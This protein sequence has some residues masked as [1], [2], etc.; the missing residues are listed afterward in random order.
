MRKYLAKR[1]FVVEKT[2][3]FTSKD[4]PA[5]TVCSTINGVSGWKNETT[6]NDA[7]KEVCSSSCSANEA[8]TCI[9]ENTFN[10]SEVIGSAYNPNSELIENS[11]WNLDISNI[12]SGQCFTLNRSTINIGSNSS[13]TFK[14][15][16]TTKGIQQFTMIHEQKLL[17]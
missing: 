6:T 17:S 13:S 9:L 7:L 12:F 16:Y 14:I 8:I 11:L 4:Q 1:T 3:K 15:I 5:I 2:E 10:F